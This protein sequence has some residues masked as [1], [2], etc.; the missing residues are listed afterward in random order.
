[1]ASW[2]CGSQEGIIGVCVCA[3]L[4]L[5]MFVPPCLFFTD[6]SRKLRGASAYAAK[7]ALRQ[8]SKT[9]HAEP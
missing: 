3:S 4:C 6:D 7:K 1:M 2:D 5:F 8:N 9:L